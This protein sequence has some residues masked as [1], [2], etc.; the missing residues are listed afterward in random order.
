MR[1][2]DAEGGL[3][4]PPPP[5]NLVPPRPHSQPLTM[6]HRLMGLLSLTLAGLGWGLLAFLL[7]H[8]VVPHLLPLLLACCGLACGTGGKPDQAARAGVS[9]CLGLFLAYALAQIL[10]IGHYY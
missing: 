2:E 4:W 1:E 10:H 7:W 8:R 9:L 6:V 3:V 5:A